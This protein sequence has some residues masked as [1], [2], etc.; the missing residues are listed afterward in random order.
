[1]MALRNREQL[2]HS[3]VAHSKTIF[4]AALLVCMGAVFAVVPYATR[5][6]VENPFPTFRI[7]LH[8]SELMNLLCYIIVCVH[9]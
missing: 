7:A 1:M 4:Q 6:E 2:R 3:N 8:H 5:T 9:R